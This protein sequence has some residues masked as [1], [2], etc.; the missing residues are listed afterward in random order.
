MF[1][2][3]L[4]IEWR[5]VESPID[6]ARCEAAKLQH[7]FVYTIREK[8]KT[9]PPHP[10]TGVKRNSILGYCRNVNIPY[11]RFARVISGRVILRLEDIAVAKLVLG[12]LYEEAIENYEKMALPLNE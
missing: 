5:P 1:G 7:A 8:I 10:V 2:K 11:D 3:Q 4:V 9:I 6:K 12:N